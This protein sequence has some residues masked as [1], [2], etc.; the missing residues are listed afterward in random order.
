[1]K[2]S[3]GTCKPSHFIKAAKIEGVIQAALEQITQTGSFRET[4]PCLEENRIRIE[5]LE[6][7]LSNLR[8]SLTRAR[9]AYLHGV[10]SLEDYIQSK[11]TFAVEIKN[12]TAKWKELNIEM[13]CQTRA[14]RK[15]SSVTEVLKCD[16]SNLA[17][18]KALSSIIDRIV[19]FR[20]EEKIIIYFSRKS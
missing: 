10:D 11:R 5:A 17:K 16:I 19:F 12:Q 18:N 8:R 14:Q 9:V 4:P 13:Q 1:V 3:H 6:A 2:Y 7:N 20:P 15:C